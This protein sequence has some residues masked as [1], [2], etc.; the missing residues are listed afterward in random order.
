MFDL[1][2]KRNKLAFFHEP[3]PL[4]SVARDTGRVCTGIAMP[5]VRVL[6]VK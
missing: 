2:R 1:R 4:S 3:V 5:S 6:L